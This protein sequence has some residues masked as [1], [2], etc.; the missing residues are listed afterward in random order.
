MRGIGR[1]VIAIVQALIIGAMI[2]V[3]LTASQAP[4]FNPTSGT[5][6]GLSMVQNQNNA[7]DALATCN[8]GGSAPGTQFLSG[9]AS[10]SDCWDDTS[11]TGWIK[12]RVYMGGAWV[13]TAYYDLTN[14]PNSLY[15][16]IVGGGAIN[17]VASATTTDLCSVNPAYLNIS[18][19]T[20]ITGFGSTCPTGTWKRLQFSGALT[21]T[22]NAAT[23]ILPG[24][25]NIT[26]AAGDTVDAVA[27]GSGNW[28]V[29]SY[30]RATGVSP[31]AA[32][33]SGT[34]QTLSGGANV[35]ANNFGTVSSGTATVDC[36]RSPLQY[37]TDNG[38]FTLAAPANDG[39]C[40]LLVTNGSSAGT[41]TFSG[42]TVGANV[43]DPLTTTNTNK[44]MVSIMHQRHRDLH[45]QGAAMRKALALVAAVALA[46]LPASAQVGPIVGG[47]PLPLNPANLYCT[48]GT[49]TTSGNTRIHS[50][51]SGG[52][53]NC[54]GSGSVTYL[55]VGGG[56]GGACQNGGGGGA[57]G[58]KS[59]TAQLISGSYTVTIG[60]GGAA[61]NCGSGT[62]G[63][64]GSPSSLGSL[65]TRTAAAAAATTASR[66]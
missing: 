50:F 65:V 3:P 60:A 20:A 34:D 42:F 18:G 35:T 22:Y 15:T 4:L 46:A 64:D 66:A 28:I 25:A 63:N 6:S 41:I 31:G 16:G 45:H 21:L 1:F 38:A 37:L 61:I 39:S 30:Q 56:G 8:A 29:T 54:V 17:S 23:L 58:F 24:G 33:L 26:T 2:A 32:S 62:T 48:G 19:T 10:N 27:L 13:V 51:I 11:T 55:V 49:I 14:A 53:L 59:A 9:A 12:R 40:A 47:V 43:G 5:L 44:F 7:N 36:G 57:G 52:T